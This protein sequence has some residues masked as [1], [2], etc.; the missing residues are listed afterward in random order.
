MTDSWTPELRQA[1]AD[2]GDAEMRRRIS[3]LSSYNAYN[4]LVSAYDVEFTPARMTAFAAFAKTLGADVI[5]D[6]KTIKA[7][8]SD[9][10]KAITVARSEVYA[11]Q[12]REREQEKEDA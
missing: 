12:A 9:E 6:D 3:E 5:M 2:L 1:A 4:T 10:E 7:A 8:K 11:R